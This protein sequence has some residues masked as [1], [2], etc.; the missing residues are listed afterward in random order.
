MKASVLRTICRWQADPTRT[1]GRCRFDPT[2]SEYGYQV[3]ERLGLVKGG[4]LTIRRVLR[5]NPWHERESD[6]VPWERIGRQGRRR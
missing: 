4:C 2:C 6:P 1:R 3:I 5:C